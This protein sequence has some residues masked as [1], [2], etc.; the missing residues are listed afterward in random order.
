MSG[1]GVI[2]GKSLFLKDKCHD[3]FNLWGKESLVVV[4]VPQKNISI[5]QNAASINLFWKEFHNIIFVLKYRNKIWKN[6]NN[7]MM[8]VTNMLWHTQMQSQIGNRLLRKW[9][10]HINY[11]K[12]KGVIKPKIQSSQT[13]KLAS[14]KRYTLYFVLPKNKTQTNRKSWEK[15]RTINI[16]ST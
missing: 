3:E 9:M 14:L 8:L 12:V 11:H 1:Y 16:V 4:G 13:N 6:S 7:Y 10:T 15:Q 2:T 5:G